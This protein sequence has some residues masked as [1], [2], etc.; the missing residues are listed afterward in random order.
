MPTPSFVRAAISAE[1]WV[2]CQEL[3]SGAPVH[4]NSG[5][6]R[7]DSSACVTQSPGSDGSASR[8]SPSLAAAASL[9]MS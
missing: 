4:R 7:C 1:T 5:P 2:P 6:P 3:F 8:P 9:A